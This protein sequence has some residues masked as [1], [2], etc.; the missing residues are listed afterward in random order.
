MDENLRV[1]IHSKRHE[2]LEPER[3]RFLRLSQVYFQQFDP[4]ICVP[5]CHAAQPPFWDLYSGRERNADTQSGDADRRPPRMP[6]EERDL[7]SRDLFYKPRSAH[8]R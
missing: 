3:L 2:H 5:A 6:G 4:L 7:W 1:P 8:K